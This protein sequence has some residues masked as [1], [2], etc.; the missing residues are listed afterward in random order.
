MKIV[1][2]SVL[3]GPSLHA[4]QPVM[5][6]IVDPGPLAG[7]TVGRLDAERRRQLEGLLPDLPVA[8]LAPDIA[9]PDFYV[10]LLTTL[11]RAAG[12]LNVSASW[13]P[14]SESRQYRVTAEHETGLVALQAARVGAGLVNWLVPPGT[15]LDADVRTGFDPALVI[16]R[17]I[18]NSRAHRLDQ[19]TEALVQEAVRRDI[20]WFRPHDH[21][22]LVQLGQGVRQIRI[23]ETITG[24]TPA[25]AVSIARSKWRTHRL[26]TDSGLP[27]TRQTVVYGPEQAVRAAESLGYPVVVKPD[28]RGG[29]LAVSVG[30]KTPGEVAAAF[31][32]AREA[33]ATVLVEAV[34]P[35]ENHRLLVV[36]GRLVAA[37]SRQPAQVVGDG[38]RTV[39]QLVEELNRDPRRGAGFAALLVRVELDAE[40]DR[41]LTAAGL[42]RKSVP[43]AGQQVV[44]RSAASIS[45]G[46]TSVDVTG[47]VHPDNRVAAERAARLVG[48]DV[49]GVDFV[50]PDI[51]RSWRDVGGAILEVNPS[52]GLRPHWN[53]EGSPDVTAAVMDAIAPPG[54]RTRIPVAAITGTNGKTTTTLLT[55]H[56]LGLD[57]RV[58]G[59]AT[60]T[61]VRIGAD[62]VAWGDRAGGRGCQMVLM[63]PGVDAAVLEFARRGLIRRGL[64]FD[65]CDVGAVLNIGTDHVGMDGIA[66]VEDL[67]RVKRLVVAHARHM[68]VLN[69]DDRLCVQL[70][71]GL[72]A[73]QTCYVSF[74]PDN[75]VVR[76]HVAAGRPA[77]WLDEAGEPTI[78][79]HDGASP[80]AVIAVADVPIT[81]GG[82][83]RHNIQNAMFAT[84]IALGLGEPLASVRAGLRSFVSA[85]ATNPGRFNLHDR[86]PFRVVVEFAH[87]AEAM[88][89]MARFA[90]AL[91][92][93]GRRAVVLWSQGNRVDSHYT[94]LANAAAGGF[95][96]FV[97]TEPPDP[98]GRPPGEISRRLADGL[99]AAGVAEE[100]IATVPDEDQA[101]ARILAGAEAGDLV[102]ICCCDAERAWRQITAFELGR[103]VS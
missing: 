84:A 56:I 40:A 74:G 68:A 54:T 25:L 2:A 58:V 33:S 37:A 73:R 83:A 19:T 53:A 75:P 71:D 99:R 20:P 77:V 91:D 15:A 35:G 28:D 97:C 69:A 66:T 50:T 67:A 65:W 88:Q 52:P 11:Q 79:F 31:Q 47:E 29:S 63:D 70:A 24:R 17:F 93:R 78:V 36:N 41:M 22:R 10:H 60:T 45:A 61:G 80:C 23:R 94:A 27:A 101:V 38:R 76:R 14:V 34:V 8:A 16:R 92:V 102:L 6:V 9:L 5:I 95:D 57:G 39:E 55:A 42:G 21:D 90:R 59:T 89:A 51:R 4:N 100:R 96:R 85:P 82:A 30:L 32:K 81:L 49:A 13:H 62:A 7:W 48:L 3:T 46:G 1:E 43:A 86:L 98:R 26:L 44:L 72:T 12:C 18:E 87:N 103:R 64:V